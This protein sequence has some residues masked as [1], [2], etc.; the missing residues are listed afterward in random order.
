MGVILAHISDE[1]FGNGYV[2]VELFFVLSGYLITALLLSEHERK[3]VINFRHFYA[4]RALRLLP[5]LYA[6]ILVWSVLG[7]LARPEARAEHYLGVLSGATYISNWVRALSP[8][9]LGPTGY[10]WSLAVEEQ[11]YVFWPPLVALL[12]RKKVKNPLWIVAFL[13]ML[14]AGWRVALSLN[15]ATSARLDN[16][17]DTRMDG[18]LLGACLAYVLAKRRPR[19]SSSPFRWTV[20]IS[21]A[22]IGWLI[23]SWVFK[24]LSPV[25]IHNFH[26]FSSTTVLC[27]IA[28]GPIVA[29]GRSVDGAVNSPVVSALSW[30]PLVRIGRLSYG[31]YLWHSVAIF[32]FA[33]R[34][35]GLTGVARIAP[36]LITLVVL[37]LLSERFV[38]QPFMRKKTR[39]HTE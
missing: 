24:T 36:T 12:L 23:A 37:A 11:F 30:P 21:G 2:G 20:W 38:E 9:T 26:G 35:L 32:L 8:H 31:L 28:I 33:S 19:H 34:R 16:G 3:G 15:G 17:L 22:V 5:A 13:V 7:V 27:L 18:L 25:W 39:F 4:R 10:L 6:C 14:T 29:F 1:Q